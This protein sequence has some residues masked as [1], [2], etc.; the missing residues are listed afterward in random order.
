[1]HR[2]AE[3]PSLATEQTSTQAW[4]SGSVRPM[5]SRPTKSVPHKTRKTSPSVALMVVPLIAGQPS[6][7]NGA[8]AAEG[9]V[10]VSEVDEVGVTLDVLS[11]E[12]LDDV[13]LTGYGG[14][15]KVEVTLALG[16]GKALLL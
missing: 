12:E 6:S 7:T 16:T 10:D 13:T 8:G 15:V 1:M 2:L 5:L 3:K 4:R 9:V 11:E 14:G